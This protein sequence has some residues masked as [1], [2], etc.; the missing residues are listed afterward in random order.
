MAQLKTTAWQYLRCPV[1]FLA[2]H[3]KD[4]FFFFFNIQKEIVRSG[5]ESQNFSTAWYDFTLPG[6]RK[7]YEK[8]FFTFDFH[9]LH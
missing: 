7:L 5:A 6:R 2:T 4:S 1:A 9:I 8:I 3:G